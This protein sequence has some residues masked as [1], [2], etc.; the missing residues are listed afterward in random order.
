MIML[1]GVPAVVGVP[2]VCWCPYA[3]A[4][5]LAVAGA[6]VGACVTLH[7]IVAAVAIC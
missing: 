4:G 2:A 5:V 6:P 1:C 7:L 3:V